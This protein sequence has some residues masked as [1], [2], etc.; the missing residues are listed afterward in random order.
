MK[1]LEVARGVKWIR[2]EK[3]RGHV[4]LCLQNLGKK[5]EIV[6]NHDP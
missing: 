5:N 6:F 2:L 1:C 3:V 4:D